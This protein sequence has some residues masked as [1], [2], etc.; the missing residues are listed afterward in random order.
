MW[1]ELTEPI[2]DRWVLRPLSGRAG[3]G[4]S[5]P[6]SPGPGV[7]GAVGRYSGGERGRPEGLPVRGPGPVFG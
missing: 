1:P 6:A 4:R 7:V 2:G 5:G 3:C